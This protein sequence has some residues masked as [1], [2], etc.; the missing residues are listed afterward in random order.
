MGRERVQARCWFVQEEDVRI[1]EKLYTD[2]DPPPLSS[3]YPPDLCAPYLGVGHVTETQLGDHTFH[4][5]GRTSGFEN[6]VA[7]VSHLFISLGFH[8]INFLGFL[9]TYFACV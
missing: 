3:R 7:K 5:D 1:E 8:V 2:T 6:V 9:F 4:L